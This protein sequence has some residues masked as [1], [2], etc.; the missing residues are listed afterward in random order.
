MMEGYLPAAEIT[1]LLTKIS[2]RGNPVHKRHPENF[3]FPSG[4]GPRPAKTLC[5]DADVFSL[6]EAQQ[7]LQEGVRRST[8]S[9]TKRGA[10]PQTVWAVTVGGRVVEARLDNQTQGTYHGFPIQPSHPIC[11]EVKQKWEAGT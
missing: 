6:D 1:T 2:Y 11:E 9:A 7:L 4:S 10:F 5:E 8:V 3:G